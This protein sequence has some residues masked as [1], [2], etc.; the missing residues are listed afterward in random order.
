M[1]RIER[2]VYINTLGREKSLTVNWDKQEEDKYF[3]LLRDLITS[4]VCGSTYKT[5]EEIVNFLAYYGVRI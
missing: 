3:C 5:K 4:E 2:Y 1:D